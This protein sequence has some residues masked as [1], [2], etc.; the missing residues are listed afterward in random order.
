MTQLLK[1]RDEWD[2]H[3]IGYAR[4]DPDTWTPIGSNGTGH[5]GHY[6]TQGDRTLYASPR[7]GKDGKYRFVLHGTGYY[8]SIDGGSIVN[9]G[10]NWGERAKIIDEETALDI[11]DPEHLPTYSNIKELV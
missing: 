4:F 8:P 6:S 5:E 7:R 1:I 9:G 11:M 10:L 3:V 2:G